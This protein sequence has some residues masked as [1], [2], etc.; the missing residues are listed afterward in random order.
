MSKWVFD[1]EADGL[2]L[3]CTRVWIV[4]AFELDRGEMRYWEEGD[5][6]WK[7]VFDD[8]ELLIG[9]NIL[10]FDIPAL[11]KIYG[12]E[13]PKT[14]NIND[15]LVMS[16][17]LDYRRFENGRHRL[18]DWGEFLNYP[19]KEF[20]DWG[21]YSEE[22]R[23]YCLQDVRLNVRVYKYLLGEY[24]ALYKKSPQ[25]KHYLRAEQAA[26]KWCTDAHLY[27]WP[28]KKQ[29]A[30]ELLHTLEGE[31]GRAHRALSSKLG[32]KAVAVDKK[33]GVVEVKRPK[34]TKAGFYDKF[35]ANWF[36]ID[37]CSGYEG[38][39]RP[40]AGEY[41]RVEFK[42]LDLN[43][44]ADVK[45][46]LSRH[47]WKPSSWNYKVI[48]GEKKKTSPKIVEEDLEILGGDGKLYPEFLTAK[49]RYNILKTWIDNVDREGRLHGDCI[50][51]GTPSMRA[52][53]SI[54][55]N[56][57]SVDSPWGKEMRN[58]FTCEPGWV[59][60]GCDSKGNQAR[61][62]AHYLNDP[63]YTEILL[64]G[65]IHQ[66]NADV[67]TGVLSKMN[68]ENEVKR[69]QAKRILYAALF[70]ASGGK[71]WSY[72]FGNVDEENGNKFKKG[73]FKAVPGFEELLDK[74][75]RIYSKTRQ[76]GPGY[77]PGIAGNR[78]YVDSYHKLLVYLLQSCEKVTCAAALMLTAE[79]LEKEGIPYKP[80]IFYHDEI[81]FQVPE[82]YATRAAGIG[83]QAFIDGP[84]LFGIDIM[85]GDAKIGKTWY[86]IH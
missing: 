32:N 86:D 22:M 2:L 27:G 13:L 11:K 72:A 36:G 81:D 26:M 5:L 48:D 7:S 17:V 84:K 51:I 73:F 3:Q 12:Y 53:H 82:E 25:I 61:G 69:A 62:L 29:E 78:I 9:H 46:F 83:K 19:K 40:I 71:L 63:E 33:N 50:T 47:G 37:P 8:A 65:D 80:C 76:Y 52:R 45:L 18:E 30:E 79:N 31:M 41:C 68:V 42:D 74:L 56:V 39:D 24:R 16:Q 43:S 20:S 14:C 23:D 28:F 44:V 38:E 4:A 55:V 6:G 34:W 15:T 49:S 35:T 64:T 58:L 54:I 67:L 59:L 60:I 10:G 21:R 77:I 85:D 57:P 1:I 66:Y 75:K 70:G